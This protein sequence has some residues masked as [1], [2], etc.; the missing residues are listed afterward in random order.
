MQTRNLRV[1]PI[2]LKCDLGL[3]SAWSSQGLC[4]PSHF[5]K[6]LDRVKVN[7]NRSKG[8]VDIERTRNSRV[9]PMT[10]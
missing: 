10:L 4:T 6:H 8:S 1:N 9:I 7:E 3:K 2:H 5:E